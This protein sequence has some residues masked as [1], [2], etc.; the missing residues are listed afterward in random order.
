MDSERVL[1]SEKQANANAPETTKP[2]PAVPSVAA[3][4]QKETQ[5][6]DSSSRC[7]KDAKAI[8]KTRGS[9]LPSKSIYD[10]NSEDGSVSDKESVIHPTRKKRSRG[11]DDVSSG[12]DSESRQKGEKK[13][14]K[15]KQ[16][17]LGVAKYFDEEA[18]VD[19]KAHGSSE[20][21]E[22]SEQLQKSETYDTDST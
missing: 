2:T 4:Q 18:R 20:S 21:S 3:V 9:N 10:E 13:R 12:D 19:N 17:K 8:A 5:L 1:E 14:Q 15:S 16:R 11:N 7:S 22:E 6:D